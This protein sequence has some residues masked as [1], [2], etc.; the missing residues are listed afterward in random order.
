MEFTSDSVSRAAVILL[1][2]LYGHPGVKPSYAVSITNNKGF[3]NLH[4]EPWRILMEIP[5][6]HRFFFF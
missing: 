2:K 1:A 5:I 4:P 6:I 3:L